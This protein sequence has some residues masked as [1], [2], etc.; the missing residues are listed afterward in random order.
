MEFRGTILVATTTWWPAPARLAMTFRRLGFRVEAIC[1]RGHPLR[2]TRAVTRCINYSSLRPLAALRQAIQTAR[3]TFVVPCDDRAT[4]HLHAL[5]EATADSSLASVISN[6]IGSAASFGLLESRGGLLDLAEAEGVRVPP[7]IPLRTET[8]L[9]HWHQ[10]LPWVIKSGMSWG[11]VGVRIVESR[12]EAVRAFRAIARPVGI[13]R[14]LKRLAINGD[15]FSVIPS[16]QRQVPEV[17]V[18]RFIAGQPAS[19]T[20]ACRHGT[21][22]AQLSTRALATQGRTG[23][24]TVVEVVEHPEMTA[25][26]DRLTASLQL[27]G[28]HGLDFILDPGGTPWLIELN[29]RATQLCH[30]SVGGGCSLAGAFAAGRNGSPILRAS[31]APAGSRIAFFPQA[32]RSDPT[33]RLLHSASHDVPWEEP[34]LVEEL[35]APP[36]PNRG[37]LARLWQKLR[38]AAGG[39]DYW[40]GTAPLASDSD[41][42][43]SEITESAAR[44]V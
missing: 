3:P 7:W 13:V 38:G 9:D 33:N 10:P 4:H 6:S 8:D 36:W 21:I 30:M 23:A 14:A 43:I 28:F 20:I 35:M 18:Q 2:H 25:A 24:S 22:L 19:T 41:S 39:T 37:R 27:T 29:P 44:P 34:D 26:A 17:L 1:P 15:G 12:A 5:Y 40:A 32:W 31:L 42:P 11:G 16:L